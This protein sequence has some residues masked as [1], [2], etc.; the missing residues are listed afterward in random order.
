MLK[1]RSSASGADFPGN[2]RS[3]AYL[4]WD[5]DGDLDIAVTNFQTPA[6]MLRNE[7]EQVDNRWLTVRL[8][9]D[10]AKK[11]S[12]DAIGARIIATGDDGLYVV[13]EIQGGSG[14]LSQNPKEQHVGLGSATHVDL[15][16]HWPSGDV[17]QVDHLP[18][19]KR[20]VIR[21][22]EAPSS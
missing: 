7:N 1:N 16:I 15:T 8:I 22:G 5:N 18:A 21:E 10:L 20:Y 13:R 11:S 17:Q 19:G 9:G 4:D 14:F 12:R 6:V 3:T 2:S